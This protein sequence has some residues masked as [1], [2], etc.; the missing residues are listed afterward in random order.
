MR[1]RIVYCRFIR[2]IIVVFF[3]L[4]GISLTAQTIKNAHGVITSVSDGG[5]WNN[6][7]TWVGGVVP[8]VDNDVIIVGTVT[9]NQA[10]ICNSLTVNVGKT[11][12]SDGNNAELIVKRNVTNKGNIYND[13]EY[14]N[15]FTLEVGRDV[16]NEGKWKKTD[17]VFTGLY[18]NRIIMGFYDTISEAR[19]SKIDTASA[20]L[21]ASNSKFYNCSFTNDVTDSP[22]F[23]TTY[24]VRV[25]DPNFVVD[26]TKTS[27]LHTVMYDGFGSFLKN[28]LLGVS[29]SNDSLFLK[30]VRLKG[31]TTVQGIPVF[32]GSHVIVE[33]TLKTLHNAGGKLIVLGDMINKGAVFRGTGNG[34]FDIEVTGDVIN[35]GKWDGANIIFK[36][37]NDNKIVMDST[38]TISRAFISKIDTGSFM[39]FA[40]DAK[41]ENCTFTNHWEHKPS[42]KNYQ[43]K[44]EKGTHF[45]IDLMKTSFLSSVK[46]DGEGG[47]LKNALLTGGYYGPAILENVHLRGTNLLRSDS[48]VFSGSHVVVDD[49]LATDDYAGYNNSYKIILNGDFVNN[50]VITSKRSFTIVA[51]GNVVNN[52]FW[53]P[54]FTEMSGATDQ[55]FLNNDSINSTTF[56]L[57]ARVPSAT[58]YQWYKNGVVIT[59]ATSKELKLH[60][61]YEPYGEYYCQTDTGVSRKITI[62]NNIT[63]IIDSEA[64]MSHLLLQNYPNPFISQTHIPFRLDEKSDVRLVIYNSVGQQV[65]VPVSGKMDAGNH[66]VLFDGTSLRPGIYYYRLVVNGVST[67]KQMVLLK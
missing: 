51:K 33:D 60:P 52:G 57:F 24:K 18:D 9:V 48:V 50:G 31:V 37:T 38:D 44:I 66:K 32:W 42:E 14:D 47:T 62:S 5:Y 28:A 12:K 15:A 45:E 63:G 20:L 49:T 8:T 17:I 56:Y 46:F 39:V 23:G 6:T 27:N 4:S 53:Q 10:A 59:S 19:I 34:S 25:A 67:T 55:T 58:T 21:I 1:K 7:T 13:T 2:I 54:G 61:Y 36:G 65:A 29:W 22:Q 35:S 40:S 3:F 30:H 11:L 64:V 26:L 16:V 41:F 43:M